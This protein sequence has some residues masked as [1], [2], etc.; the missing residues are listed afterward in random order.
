MVAR[1]PARVRVLLLLV[2][3]AGLV[4]FRVV[5]ERRAHGER[6][7]AGASA[8]ASSPVGHRPFPF[9][10]RALAA[11]EHVAAGVEVADALQHVDE[12]IEAAASAGTWG[13]Q[14]VETFEY[15]TR[16]LGADA[17]FEAHRRLAVAINAH[18]FKVTVQGM[19]L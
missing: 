3:L 1:V 4:A 18:R 5:R 17:L 12:V 8:M 14:Q 19:P 9:G 6:A 10:A 16:N 11:P 2:A 15:T 13:P 7:K